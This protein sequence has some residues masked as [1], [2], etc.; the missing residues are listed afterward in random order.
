M[1]TRLISFVADC[2]YP[3][4]HLVA[5][6]QEDQSFFIVEMQ[7]VLGFWF[8]KLELNPG[9]YRF[10]YYFADDRQTTYWNPA[11]TAESIQDGLDAVL[12]V[13][14]SDQPTRIASFEAALAFS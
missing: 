11:H 8:A 3:K 4:L 6:R 5:N 1:C 2:P 10:R 12:A 13:D 9:T 14:D 7:K